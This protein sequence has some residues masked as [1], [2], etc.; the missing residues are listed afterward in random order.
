MASFLGFP[1]VVLGVPS[2]TVRASQLEPGEWTSGIEGLKGKELQTSAGGS[3]GPKAMAR[4][5]LPK[6]P[7]VLVLFFFFF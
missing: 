7:M 3:K 4:D 2:L 5:Q 1:N 6:A